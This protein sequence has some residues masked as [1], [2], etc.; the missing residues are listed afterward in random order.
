MYFFFKRKFSEEFK[1]AT[2]YLLDDKLR[3]ENAET[4][5]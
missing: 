4:M 2:N 3:I 1:Y 5:T